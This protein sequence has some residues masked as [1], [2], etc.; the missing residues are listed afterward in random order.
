MWY[1]IQTE[2]INDNANSNGLVL[3]AAKELQHRTNCREGKMLK[4][5]WIFLCSG[6]SILRADI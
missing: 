5:K 4:K 3:I 6:K 1:P 2:N